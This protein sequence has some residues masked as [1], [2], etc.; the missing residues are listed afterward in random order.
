[1]C[2]FFGGLGGGTR[3]NITSVISLPKDMSEMILNTVPKRG[4][5]AKNLCSRRDLVA[6]LFIAILGNKCFRAEGI[7]GA[8]KSRCYVSILSHRLCSRCWRPF[9]N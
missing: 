7:G 6:E 1:V 3:F 9:C 5:G 2:V 4:G 8:H